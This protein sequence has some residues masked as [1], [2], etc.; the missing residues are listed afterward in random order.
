MPVEAV[1]VGEVHA[2]H[3]EPVIAGQVADAVGRFAVVGTLGHVDVHTDAVLRGQ[4]GGRRQRVVGARER[5]VD[6]D[7]PSPAGAQVAVVLVEAASC[8]VG[9]V[10]VGHAVG[11]AHAHAD[12]GAGVG[13]DRQRAFDGV[14]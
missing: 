7:H 12:L 13:D 14:R 3:D 8:A 9:T 11:G 5:G 4:L 2:V 10:A 1:V 6:T